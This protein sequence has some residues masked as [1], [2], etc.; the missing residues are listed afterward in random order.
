[1][2]VP[3][4]APAAIVT[5]AGTVAADVLSEESATTA[6]V[7]GGAGESSVIVPVDVAPEATEIGFSVRFEIATTLTGLTVR[8]AVLSVP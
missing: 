7:V 2:N 1:V 8:V 5:V 6:P 3:V 4:V